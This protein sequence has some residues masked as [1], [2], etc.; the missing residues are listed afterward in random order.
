MTTPATTARL[1]AFANE[2]VTD[3]SVPANRAAAEA[4]L[5]RVRAEL[6]RDHDLWIAGSAH[7]TGDL[8]TSLNP[9]KTSE[10][11][12]RHHKATPELATRAIEDAHAFFGEWSRVPTERRIELVVRAA[13]LIR[14]R[15]LDFDAWL[16]VEAGKTGPKP[17][18]MSAKPSISPNTTP[19]RCRSSTRPSP[20]SSCPAS[21]TRCSI[22]R[23]APA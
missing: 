20:P 14:K 18:P 11:V 1:S 21:M 22:F 23:S 17:M 5:V 2:P 15:K 10:V 13:A 7:K 3:F 6:G 8:L 9:S 16:V 4:A 19:A 12:G